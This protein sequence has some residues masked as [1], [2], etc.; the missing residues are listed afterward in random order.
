MASVTP[1]FTNAV[2][3]FDGSSL[4]A[5]WS[6]V[7]ANPDGLP[8]EYSEWSNKTWQVVGTNWGGATLVIQGSNDGTNWF[9]MNNAAGSTALS[10]TTGAG[11]GFVSIETPRYVRPNLSVVGAAADVKVLLHANRATPMRK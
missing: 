9:T 6:L 3:S 10:F 11:F 2:G 1:T 8:M 5:Q 7:T 4:V